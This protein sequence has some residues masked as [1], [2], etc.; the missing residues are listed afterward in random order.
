VIAAKTIAIQVTPSTTPVNRGTTPQRSS[1]CPAM[2]KPSG[3]AS[4][5][6]EIAAVI[7][8]AR[9]SGGG[10]AVSTASVGPF[11]RGVKALARKR[12]QKRPATAA[13]RAGPQRDREG[14]DAAGGEPQWR[15]ALHEQILAGARRCFAEHGYE[16]ATVVR[17]EREIGLSRGA[18][19]NY[20]PSKEDLFIELAVRDSARL[21]EVWIEEGLDGVVREVVELD[22][23]VAVRRPRA[24]TPRSQ[25]PGR[26]GAHRGA[27]EVGGAGEPGT[28]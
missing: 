13:G 12:A 11:I 9:R 19:F 6:T 27:A 1:T 20:F 5:L 15:E 22:P 14:E 4:V 18:I 26:P 21:S 25:R 28:H 3:A 2:R 10:R 16:G 17:L 8:L 23:R 7:T 24:V